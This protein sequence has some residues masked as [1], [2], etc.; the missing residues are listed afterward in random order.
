ML[1][2]ADFSLWACPKIQTAMWKNL[3]ARDRNGF[4][5]SNPW[6]QL[7]ELVNWLQVRD[8]RVREAEIGYGSSSCC[9]SSNKG[10]WENEISAYRLSQLACKSGVSGALS[11]CL[12]YRRSWV[13][14][15]CK[16]RPKPCLLCVISWTSA[17]QCSAV[18]LHLLKFIRV[19]LEVG[20]WTFV[21][22]H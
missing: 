22:K 13:G 20:H 7:P 5:A 9:C 12:G 2:L 1:F 16:S 6:M 10:G 3:P 15:H 18:L 19:N 4:S 14:K 11:Y 17:V 8:T 21:T